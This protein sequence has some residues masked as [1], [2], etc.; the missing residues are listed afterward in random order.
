MANSI[1]FV[2]FRYC[3][4]RAAV[5]RSGDNRQESDLTF[6]LSGYFE[7]SL[8]R[9]VM[10]DRWLKAGVIASFVVPTIIGAFPIYVSIP[11]PH[12]WTLYETANLIECICGLLN[13]GI[14]VFLTVTG[15]TNGNSFPLIIAVFEFFY[16][17]PET[18]KHFLYYH[19]GGWDSM[20]MVEEP[21]NF[22]FFCTASIAILLLVLENR[23]IGN[24]ALKY[25]EN[26]I[27]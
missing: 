15:Q 13:F 10:I 17:F 12:H 23:K 9:P 1:F 26:F 19:F 8:I 27:V 5:F 20:R 3:K 16:A 25:F 2:S 18:V 22:S 6:Y 24:A 11:L 7:H 21:D 4:S 14:A